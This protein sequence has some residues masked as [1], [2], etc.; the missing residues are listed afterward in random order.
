[1]SHLLLFEVVIHG[2]DNSNGFHYAAVGHSVT[3]FAAVAHLVSRQDRKHSLVCL[4]NRSDFAS[5]VGGETIG[6]SARIASSFG[7][8]V[9]LNGVESSELVSQPLARVTA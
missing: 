4:P 6:R 5:G 1:M 9:G 2:S 8:H 3:R 7:D